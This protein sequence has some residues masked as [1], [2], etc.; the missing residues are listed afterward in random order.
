MIRTHLL[1]A[2]AIGSYM[3]ILPETIIQED[4][5]PGIQGRNSMEEI[6]I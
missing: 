1:D 3:D 4:S 2:I 5:V 6:N